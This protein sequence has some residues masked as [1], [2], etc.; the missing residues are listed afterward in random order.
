MFFILPRCLNPPQ[1]ASSGQFMSLIFQ[2]VHYY[3]SRYSQ[4]STY[5]TSW[6]KKPN[7]YDEETETKPMNMWL[8]V[9]DKKQVLVF[10]L[11]F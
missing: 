6:K 2:K 11:L 3:F 8:A 7:I 1:A 5:E 10:L 4:S 9:L